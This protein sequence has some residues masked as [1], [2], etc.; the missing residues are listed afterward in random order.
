[1]AG[2]A[3]AL[4]GEIS[5]ELGGGVC[6]LSNELGCEIE[7]GGEIGAELCTELCTRVSAWA[8]A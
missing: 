1:M 8:A 5:S 4:P 2:G 6:A 3:P 7:T